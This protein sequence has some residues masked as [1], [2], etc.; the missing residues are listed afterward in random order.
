[1][2]VEKRRTQR[3]KGEGDRKGIGGWKRGWGEGERESWGWPAH[4]VHL[5][6]DDFK[7]L[8]GPWEEPDGTSCK[9]TDLPDSP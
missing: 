8:L 9:L 5:A 4:L 1:M 6:D 3:R 7:L 2:S